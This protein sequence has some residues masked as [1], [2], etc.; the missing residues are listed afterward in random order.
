MSLEI[1]VQNG[2][3]PAGFCP[4]TLQEM[5]AGFT[6]A[7]FITLNLGVGTGIQV[8]SSK[9]TNTTLPWFQLDSNGNPVRI[10]WFANGAWLSK[11]PL[12]PG[13]SIPW[14]GTLPTTFVVGGVT[15][16]TF[17]EGTTD[18]LS[19][20]SGPFW[21][22][23]GEI[24]AR[25]PLACGTLPSTLVINPGD[26]GGEEKHILLETEMPRHT[27]TVPLYA[28]DSANHANRINTTDET[29]AQN[30]NY[31]S[32]AAGGDAN[33][34]TVGHNTLPPYLGMNWLRRTSRL[35]YAVP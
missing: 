5:L 3:L 2:N 14:F 17:D 30:L 18:P 11:H 20:L 23:V 9:P 24:A 16:T 7:Q 28:G 32:G 15:Y 10:Y 22:V 4:S 35:F 1:P 31:Q 19:P 34:D 8:Q 21:E 33:G 6:E 25:V 26:T 12:P 27:H 13:L 29:T